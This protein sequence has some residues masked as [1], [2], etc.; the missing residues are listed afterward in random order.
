VRVCL[1]SANSV[2]RDACLTSPVSGAY[3]FYGLPADSYK[4][5]FSATAAEIPDEGAKADAYP[6]QWW[7]GATSFATATPIS[8]TPPAIVSG[9]DAALGPPPVAPVV[10]PAVVPPPGAKKVKPK[11]K[12]PLRC[13]KHFAKRKV[14]GKVKCVRI[15]KIVRHKHHHQKSA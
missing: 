10:P 8:I 11:P 9:I 14:H 7:Q 1:T 12:P 3:R 4:I 15:H 6:T 5:A 2:E 13:R